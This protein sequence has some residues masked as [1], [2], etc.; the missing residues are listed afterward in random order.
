MQSD[1]EL[2]IRYLNGNEEAL[3]EL[4][5]RHLKIVFNFAYRYV[6]N[7]HDAEDVTQEVFIK[8]WK[9]IEKFDTEKK[10]TTW[11]L[12]ITRNTALDHLKKKGVH[13]FADF[14]ND[15]GENVLIEMLKDDSPLPDDLSIQKEHKAKLQ[16]ALVTL[17]PHQ[18]SVLSLHYH[19]GLTF[20]QIGDMLHTSLNTVKSW[21]RRALLLLK[22]KLEK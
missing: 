12:T 1:K 21:H 19:D 18:R 16:A 3:Q 8:I 15:A 9:H 6:G 10:F 11:I 17:N 2:I 20:A 13:V 14:E 4:I 22:E 7:M 5:Q